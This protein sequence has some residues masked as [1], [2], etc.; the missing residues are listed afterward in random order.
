M[1]RNI[2]DFLT[3]WKYETEGTLKVFSMITEETRQLKINEHVRSLERLGWHLTQS[4]AEMGHKAGLFPV[5]LLEN[6]PI[7]DSISEL[8]N[9]Y[10]EY[11]ELLSTA[12]SSK[13]TDSSLQDKVDM[14]G[15]EW[16]KSKILQVLILHQTHHRGQ[17]TVIM[18][19]LELPVPGI[20]GPSKEEWASMGMQPMD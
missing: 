16:E 17:M 15:E 12:V 10:Q 2:T 6:N 5:D 14:Y 11:C 20:Y 1:Y 3:D 19:V 9:T 4:I 8:L 13:W 18:R 7:P